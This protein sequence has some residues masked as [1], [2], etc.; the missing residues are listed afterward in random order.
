VR[1]LH[2]L[3]KTWLA[4]A[5]ARAAAVVFFFTHAQ[6]QG[7]QQPWHALGLQLASHVSVTLATGTVFFALF[8]AYPGRLT[9]LLGTFSALALALFTALDPVVYALAGDHLT[10]AL[11]GH[12]AGPQIFTSDYL[13]KPI[14]A[15][16]WL[17]G[18]AA[19]LLVMLTAAAV[20]SVRSC[21]SQ[22]ATFS[23]RALLTGVVFG[24]IVLVLPQTVEPP[25]EVIFGRNVFETTSAPNAEEIAALRAFV[26]LAPGE[27]WLSDVFP[28]VHSRTARK[29]PFLPDIVVVSIESLRGADLRFISH[30]EGALVLPALETLASQS[31]VFS[32]FIS[33][34]FPSVE[35]F[36]STGYSAFPHQ[37][38]RIVIEYPHVRLDGFARRLSHFGYRTVRVEDAPNANEEG[39][40]IKRDHD[41]LRS[42]PGDVYWSERDMV[43][44]TLAWLAHHDAT[45]SPGPV[46]IDFKT[47]HPHMPY[48]IA[49]DA[50]QNDQ[51]LGSPDANYPRSLAYVD[52]E[53]G[54]LFAALRARPRWAQ[55]IVLVLGDHSNWRK[56]SEGS[57]LPSDDMVWT[58]A[59]L[60]GGDTRLGPPRVITAPAS[61]VDVAPTLLSLV[62]DD[63]PSAAVGR[64][65]LANDKPA[66]AFAIRPGGLRF[67]DPYETTL[68]VDRR[69]LQGG[70][71]TQAFTLVP[72]TASETA[73]R[74]ADMAR[75]AATWSR[76]VELDRLWDPSFIGDAWEKR[77]RDE[78]G[79]LEA[80]RPVTG[81]VFSS[82]GIR[83]LQVVVAGEVVTQIVPPKIDRADV[84]EA[85]ATLPTT[86][87]RASGFVI[88]YEGAGE[89]LVRV[90]RNDGSTFELRKSGFKR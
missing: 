11:F 26:G 39:A 20:R 87:T 60:G 29:A 65:L 47:A 16:A 40:W 62:G 17:S 41:E 82:A 13:W 25:P 15:H 86:L 35:G 4:L 66:Q 9:A 31:V 28:L 8:A 68:L 79:Y 89:P 23:L 14:K 52:A 44:D 88:P 30:R 63:R 43:N 90:V 53:L 72:A 64:D 75:L 24:A 2:P 61:Q 50:Q 80:F 38:S 77:S 1:S 69:Y 6:V 3:Q 81:W 74:G 76:L 55:T 78:S 27:R 85:F 21:V 10:P 18:A 36:L 42:R 83:S 37:R 73:L 48:E 54:R 12:Y 84:A 45:S 46:F 32:H 49:D 58:G 22:R 33:N 67:D 51:S 56:L 70:R 19:L 5:A 71:R 7:M 57:P 34:G 59:I